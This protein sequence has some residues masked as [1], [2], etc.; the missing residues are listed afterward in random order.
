MERLLNLH[1]AHT[2]SLAPDG[3]TLVFL[4]DAPGVAQPFSAAVGAQPV[5]EAQ[6]RRL[7]TVDDRVHWA[8]YAPSG[9]AVLF[10]R[11]FGGDENVQ[12]SSPP[13]AT[14]ASAG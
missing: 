8:Q 3:R 6:W 13:R 1:R 2:P 10:G 11:D 12:L 5:A 9:R 14:R 4:S 7:A